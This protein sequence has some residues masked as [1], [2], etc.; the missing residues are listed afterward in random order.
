[1]EITSIED[2]ARDYASYIDVSSI[3]EKIEEAYNSGAK[4]MLN[5]ITS[6]LQESATGSMNPIFI[7]IIND[8]NLFYGE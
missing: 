4:W 1:M 5:E 8:L 6:Y 2:K 7:E 3:N